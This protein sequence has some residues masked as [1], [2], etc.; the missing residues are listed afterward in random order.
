MLDRA[1]KRLPRYDTSFEATRRLFTVADPELQR[2]IHEFRLEYELVNGPTDVS[3]PF[4]STQAPLIQDKR[5][6]QDAAKFIASLPP[7]IIA[8]Y[9]E[10]CQRAVAEGR[11]DDISDR[12]LRVFMANGGRL[13]RAV[14][15]QA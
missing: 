8:F 3:L 12:I 15:P 10:E 1:S 13:P 6:R 11:L 2:Q 5:Y 14:F 7:F 9:E 4:G